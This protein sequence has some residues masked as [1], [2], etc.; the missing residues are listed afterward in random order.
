MEI[1]IIGT[2]PGCKESIVFVQRFFVQRSQRVGYIN[3][4]QLPTCDIHGSQREIHNGVQG[5]GDTHYLHRNAHLC[6]NDGKTHDGATG[7]WRYCKRYE[8][9]GNKCKNQPGRG[10]ILGLIIKTFVTGL[11][12]SDD[13]FVLSAS[14]VPEQTAKRSLLAREC[15]LFPFG[16]YACPYPTP[17][18]L[19]DIPEYTS[20]RPSGHES[21]VLTS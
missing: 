1:F 3:H 9:N 17:G 19:V 10:D 12:C 7:H 15:Y 8:P 18:R 5:D 4:G 13:F 21:S 6:K 11:H 16:E 14:A 20:H 2:V